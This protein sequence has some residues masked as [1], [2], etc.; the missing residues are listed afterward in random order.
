ME[1]TA[2]LEKATALIAEQQSSIWHPYTQAGDAQEALCV[3]HAE[4]ACLYTKDGREIIDAISSWWVTLHGHRDAHTIEKIQQQLERLEHVMLAG[5]VHEPA[6]QLADLLLEILPIGYS[7]VFYS[8]NGSTATETALKI[9]LQYWYNQDPQTKRKKVVAFKNGYHGETFGAMSASERSL[10]SGPF[11]HAL[12]DVE[13]I[14]PPIEG[15]EEQSYRQLESLLAEGSYACFI[16]EPLVQGAAGMRVHSAQGLDRL[17]SLCKEYNVL[18]IA[19]EVMTGFGRLGLNF[20]IDFLENS[21]DM[22]CLAKSMTGGFLPLA[23]TVCK[24]DLY[25]R[26]VDTDRAKAFLHGH[27]YC[28]NPLGCAAAIATIERLKTQE[29][30]RQREWIEKSHI[31]FLEKWKK[32][33]KLSR[34]QVM[35][36]LL[37]LEY[38]TTEKSSYYNSLRNQLEQ[39][40]LSQDILMR[41]IGN[42]VYVLPPFCITRKQ[43][44][45]VYQAIEQ[46]LEEAYE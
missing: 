14:D 11:Q 41:P 26:F 19:D 17:L 4:G 5:F 31:E 27:T 18:T 32:S 10:F 24:K 8:D 43:L 29:S 36:T 39:H 35:G 46:T 37:V 38:A 30:Y 44:Y 3:E 21:P 34:A 20:A 45:K 33:P 2:L 7:K 9:A 1:R 13:F 22:I 15:S 23:A 40:F 42:T 12:F 6:M 28:G 16:F 25:E